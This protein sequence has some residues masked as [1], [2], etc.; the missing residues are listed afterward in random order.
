MNLVLAYLLHPVNFFE[1][2]REFSALILSEQFPFGSCLSNV[3]LNVT[4]VLNPLSKNLENFGRDY[5]S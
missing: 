5:Q 2:Q 1:V 4:M 3:T